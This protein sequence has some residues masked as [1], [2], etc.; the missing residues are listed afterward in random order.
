MN[1]LFG[2]IWKTDWPNIG[3]D[4]H[5]VLDPSVKDV[6]EGSCLPHTER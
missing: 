6:V 4:E 3:I 2:G 1:T 5:N